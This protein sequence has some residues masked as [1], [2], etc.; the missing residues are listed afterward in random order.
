M[1]YPIYKTCNPFTIQTKPRLS[2][3]G[4]IM[5]DDEYSTHRRTMY[6]TGREDDDDCDDDAAISDDAIASRKRSGSSVKK[7]K[8][9]T[10]DDVGG[11]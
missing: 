3:C 10:I 6:N 1:E 7:F 2:Y 11:L 8:Y 5:L 9:V 4:S